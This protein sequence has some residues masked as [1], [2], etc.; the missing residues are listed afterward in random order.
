MSIDGSTL[1]EELDRVD[2]NV[3]GLYQGV[4]PDLES[5]V[6]EMETRQRE[7]EAEIEELRCL[8]AQLED[9]E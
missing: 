6:A 9:D 2:E 4:I 8:I 1:H 3:N 5:R 7:F